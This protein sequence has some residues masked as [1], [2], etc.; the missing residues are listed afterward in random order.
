[1]HVGAVEMAQQLRALSDPTEALD[2]VPSAHMMS[3]HLPGD[4][5]PSS[6]YCGILMVHT[7]SLTSLVHPHGIIEIFR[8]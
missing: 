2:S 6:D 8:R 7:N 5:L 3:H 4:L 1:M